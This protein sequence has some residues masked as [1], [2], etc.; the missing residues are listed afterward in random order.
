MPDVGFQVHY[1][2]LVLGHQF[3]ELHGSIAIC[4]CAESVI[5]VF[6]AGVLQQEALQMR[7]Q[8]SGSFSELRFVRFLLCLQ[9]SELFLF[10]SLLSSSRPSKLTPIAAKICRSC[11]ALLEHVRS[12]T[13]ESEAFYLTIQLSLA[14]LMLL[15]KLC[16]DEQHG[17]LGL[18]LGLAYAFCGQLVVELEHAVPKSF[19]SCRNKRQPRTLS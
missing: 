2:R 14:G 7:L 5:I 16:Q 9:R 15:R 6:D 12:H 11:A 19:I 17:I 1:A 10:S 3:V 18:F 13:E 8:G 4:V